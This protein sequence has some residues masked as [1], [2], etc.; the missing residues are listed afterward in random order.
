[1]ITI[2]R[3]FVYQITSNMGIKLLST[4]YNKYNLN[5]TI[6]LSYYSG[7][8]IVIDASI[9]LITFW[10]T[11][12][13]TT[14]SKLDVINRQIDDMIVDIVIGHSLTLLLLFIRNFRRHNISLIFVLDGKAPE[15]K[16]KTILKRMNRIEKS[17]IKFMEYIKENDMTNED[18]EITNIAE[19]N[20]IND[21]KET[22]ILNI[23]R[24]H[25]VDFFPIPARYY[26]ECIQLLTSENL[27]FMRA[28][29]EA[30][31][32]CAALC[33]EGVCSAVY[34]KDTDVFVHG[35]PIVITKVTNNSCNVITLYDMLNSLGMTY[36]QF[37]DFAI[38]CGCD[39]N[40]TIKR[41]GI[42]TA[43]KLINTY[44]S[45]DNLPSNIDI[46]SLNHIKCRELFSSV[47]SESLI[48]KTYVSNENKA[49]IIEKYKI[50][51]SLLYLV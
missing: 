41:V 5:I 39:Y 2:I 34:T 17:Q 42:K 10:K 33:R 11:S 31:R 19:N 21:I 25:L 22:T 35:C 51:K 8:K 6:P 43:Q 44:G 48:D 23:A 26:S 37:V 16:N 30:E 27:T 14:I 32:L 28:K 12:L 13:A 49:N 7:K 38:I 4:L 1:M 45:I 47:S 50:N 9:Q 15:E 46:S 20:K 3:L 18:K 40:T 24:K 36:E 29:G